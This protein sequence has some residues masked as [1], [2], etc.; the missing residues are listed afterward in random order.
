[1]R[2]EVDKEAWPGKIREI[3]VEMIMQL[4]GEGELK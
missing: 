1:V 3:I 4:Q 2:T